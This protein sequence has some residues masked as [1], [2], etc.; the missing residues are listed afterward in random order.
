MKKSL[1]LLLSTFIGLSQAYA[2]E[3]LT[4][5]VQNQNIELVK[6]KAGD[7]YMGSTSDEL[8]RN[9]NSDIQQFNTKIEKDFYISKFETTQALYLAVMGINPSKNNGLNNPVER[10]NFYNAT[11]FCD[12]L[13]EITKNSRPQGYKFSLP[14]EK[15][16]EYA[17]RA[18]TKTSLNNGKQISQT[19]GK[20]DELD[21]ISWYKG[22]SDT[23]THEVGTKKPNSWG[24]YDMHG[25]VAEWCLDSFNG[26]E[27]AET[28]DDNSKCVIR[29]GAYFY[30]P[31]KL[32]SASRGANSPKSVSSGIGFRVAL[33]SDETHINPQIDKN[34]LEKVKKENEDSISISQNKD[35]QTK[36][37]E[38]ASQTNEIQNTVS[39][40][41]A[42]P[43]IV[44]VLNP[45]NNNSSDS[46][47]PQEPISKA[48]IPN[49][50]I[51][52]KT[53]KELAIKAGEKISISYNGV[54]FPLIG[55]PAG[56]FLMGSPNNETGRKE[57]EIQRKAT[58]SKGFYIG[59]YE[60]TQGQYKSIMGNNPSIIIGDKLPVH[61]LNY[62]DAQNFCNKLNELTKDKRP[63][64]YEFDIPTEE[65]WEYA[66][67]SGYGTSLNNGKNLINTNSADNELNKIAWYSINACEKVQTVGKR[68]ANAWGLHDMLGNV[69]EWCKT[70]NT[71]KAVIKG[72]SF[73][74]SASDCRNAS[75]KE[76]ESNKTNEDYGFRIILKPVF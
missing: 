47:K 23:K 13:N 62:F 39:E 33:V 16:W 29:G 30:E 32:R 45:I 76:I 66:S 48:E 34:I 57:D 17:C 1:L 11:I 38:I 14:T 41:P 19:K 44:P 24:I 27:I 61:N 18:D 21:E 56:E 75:R 69:W 9:S 40:K 35:I 20:S 67:R 15:Q 36:E 68:T 49:E 3:E 59:K 42:E 43:I 28:I 31:E 55:C 64:N 63:E 73:K 72:G 7:F 58:I 6:C 25:N 12:K 70:D 52:E 8:G 4:I 65:Q 26:S 53:F 5:K 71:T 50:P 51:K 37:T 2:N 22:N 60:I 54:K 74:S 46:I 10:V